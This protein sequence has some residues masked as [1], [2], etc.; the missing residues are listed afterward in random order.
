MTMASQCYEHTIIDK[1]FSTVMSSLL[2]THVQYGIP[3]LQACLCSWQPSFIDHIH[4][5]TIL[6]VIFE[7]IRIITLYGI[8][9][10]T[11]K[12]ILFTAALEENTVV[13]EFKKQNKRSNH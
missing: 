5:T 4:I 7:R 6:D 9:D 11:C 13:I 8:I 12:F 3:G 2:T 1:N 10:R